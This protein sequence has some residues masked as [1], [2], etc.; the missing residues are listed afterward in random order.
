VATTV[1]LDGTRSKGNGPLSCTWSFEN[2]DG[3]AVWETQSGC[4]LDKTFLTPGTKY[5]ELAVR[6]ADGDT[7][8]SKQ[9]FSVRL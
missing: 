5:V 6:D 3:S 7:D 9:S 4:K 1:T 8:S 2:Q